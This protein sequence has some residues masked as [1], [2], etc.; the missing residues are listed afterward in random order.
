MIH[1]W[2]DQRPRGFIQW[3]SVGSWGDQRGREPRALDLEGCGTGSSW[4]KLR[5]IGSGASRDTRDR[6]DGCPDESIQQTAADVN[7]A[8]MVQSQR[9]LIYGSGATDR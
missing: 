3:A 9:S 6:H 2:P 8:S 1:Q 5:S 4:E 7:V